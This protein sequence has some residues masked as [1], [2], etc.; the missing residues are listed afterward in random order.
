MGQLQNTL[1]KGYAGTATR[2]VDGTASKKV[3]N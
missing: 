3:I 1:A 2:K